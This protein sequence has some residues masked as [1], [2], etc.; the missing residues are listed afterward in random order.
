MR[1]GTNDPGNVVSL[2]DHRRDPETERLLL[3][4]DAREFVEWGRDGLDD[5][6]CVKDL[7][8]RLADALEGGR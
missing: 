4:A 3:I 7:I 8:R 2:D 5:T 6:R 1:D